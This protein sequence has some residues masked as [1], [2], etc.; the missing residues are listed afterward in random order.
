MRAKL[1]PLIWFFACFACNQGK[2]Q[3]TTPAKSPERAKIIRA[4]FNSPL[5]VKAKFDG[6][7]SVDAK[8]FAEFL[9]KSQK[10]TAPATAKARYF[11]RIED[12][13]CDELYFA[14][15]GDFTMSAG[16]ITK[17]EAAKGRTVYSVTF[18]RELPGGVRDNQGAILTV[19]HSEKRLLLEFPDYKLTFFPEAEKPASL[20]EQFTTGF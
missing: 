8:E 14:D 11:L 1:I 12:S 9:A 6:F 4:Y 13:Y 18:N 16:K 17:L 10:S 3:T 15:G 20:A 5:K 19:F 2:P 7:W